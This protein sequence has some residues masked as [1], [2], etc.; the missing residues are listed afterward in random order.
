MTCV[1]T[2]VAGWWV[3]E[4]QEFDGKVYGPKAEEIRKFIE[5]PKLVG[6]PVE[7]A[8]DTSPDDP[9]IPYLKEKGWHLVSPT[10]ATAD[11]SAYKKYVHE[12]FG[13]FSCAKGLYAGTNGG[14]FSDRSACYLAAGRPVVVQATGFD[15][16][17]PTGKGL[18]SVKNVEEAAEAI[19]AIRLDYKIHS[20]AARTI[21]M[22]YFDSNKV[23]SNLMKTI[24]L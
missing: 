16:V 5:L 17:L 24:G 8:L 22:E 10:I 21:A 11:A 15:D 2:T 12:S 4:Y 9:E 1:V 20:K 6:E 3:N 13:E 19:K 23:L 14:W 7:I 18:F